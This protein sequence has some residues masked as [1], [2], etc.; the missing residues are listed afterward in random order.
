M[1]ILAEPPVAV[2]DKV[3]DG[4]ARRRVAQAYLEFLYTPEGQES[5]RSTTTGR[6]REVLASYARRSRRWSS[7]PSTRFGGW[8][9]AQKTHFDDGGVFD[10]I[11]RRGGGSRATAGP[12]PHACCPASG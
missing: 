1:S 12:A 5:R 11:Y 10:Q 6:G 2:V 9:K 8:Q 3:V 7:S 4:A